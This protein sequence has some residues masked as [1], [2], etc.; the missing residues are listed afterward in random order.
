VP[1]AGVIDDQRIPAR[2]EEDFYAAIADFFSITKGFYSLNIS[3]FISSS[4][5]NDAPACV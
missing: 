1:S 4:A 2:W 5:G 3:T